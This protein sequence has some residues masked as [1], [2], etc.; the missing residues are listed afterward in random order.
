[1]GIRTCRF[2]RAVSRHGANSHEH[3]RPHHSSKMENDMNDSAVENLVCDCCEKAD[4]SILRR[5]TCA[6]TG[7]KVKWSELEYEL[8]YDEVFWI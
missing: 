7:K 3:V 4:W 6:K 2:S 1:M 5:R 8:E